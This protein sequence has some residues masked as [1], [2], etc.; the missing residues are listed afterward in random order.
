MAGVIMQRAFA[1]A[2]KTTREVD[3]SFTIHIPGLPGLVVAAKTEEA[4]WAMLPE[5]M[6]AWARTANDDRVRAERRLLEIRDR[7]EDARF[8]AQTRD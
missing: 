2:A 3:G 4:A 6:I 8:E 7:D 5:V 1:H